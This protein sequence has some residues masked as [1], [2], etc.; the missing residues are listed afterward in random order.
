ML[1]WD[2]EV[3]ETSTCQML[4]PR[5]P[6]ICRTSFDNGAFVASCPWWTSVLEVAVVGCS[7]TDS[8]SRWELSTN[9]RLPRCRNPKTTI[10]P[11]RRY[12]LD[13]RCLECSPSRPCEDSAFAVARLAAEPAALATDYSELYMYVVCMY[14]YI[15][16]CIHIYIYIYIHMCWLMYVY[17]YI[18]IYT[19]IYIYICDGRNAETFA[20]LERQGRQPFL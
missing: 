20:C 1:R 19:Y 5:L 7:S 13:S 6:T 18:Y 11:L 3:A 16:I 15:Y 2:K 12:P 8:I 4:S 17:I 14:V 10:G 9:S